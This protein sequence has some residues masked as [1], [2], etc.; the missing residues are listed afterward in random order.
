[1]IRSV[2][3]VVAGFAVMTVCVMGFTLAA[4]VV[5]Y[6]G[7]PLD[8]PIDPSGAWI[9]VNL[10]YS[11]LAAVAGGWVTAKIATR[12]RMGHAG[13]LALVVLAMSVVGRLAGESASGAQPGWY[14]VVVTAVGIGGVLIGGYLAA[15]AS[16]PARETVAPSPAS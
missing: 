11:L 5:L 15:R 9:A 8:A 3:S 16:G 10:A 13:A 14:P 4:M 6:P 7:R 12:A 2:L 1:M